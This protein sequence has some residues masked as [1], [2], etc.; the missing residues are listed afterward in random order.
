MKRLA[1]AML[2]MVCLTL[3]GCGLGSSDSSNINGTWNAT[4]IDTNDTTV[5]SFGTSLVVNNN[6]SLSITNFN[7]TTNSPCFVS[8]GTESG[9]FTLSGDFNGNVN[10]KFGFVVQSSSPIGNTLTLSGTA[11]GNTISGNWTLTGGTG[12]TG[13]GSFT[14][15]R[16]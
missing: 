13:S 3:V 11:N 5:F 12:C 7:F 8:S 4:L 1:K 14:M 9:S 16:T 6:G 15:I 2:L 10:G